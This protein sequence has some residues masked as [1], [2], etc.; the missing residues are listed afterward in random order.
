MSRKTRWALVPALS[1]LL[2]VAGCSDDDTSN[3]GVDQ[4]VTVD[5]GT[6]QDQG[7]GQ[8]KG[9]PPDAGPAVDGHGTTDG[10]PDGTS[11]QDDLGIGSNSGAICTQ[12]TPCP[13]P[14]ETCIYFEAALGKGMCLASCQQQGDT[15][16]VADKSTQISVCSVTGYQPGTWL[17]G[18]FCEL[19]GKT[20]KCPNDTD[21]K[22]VASSNGVA[23]FCYPK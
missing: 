16:P 2:L 10:I 23:Q 7:T 17:C 13:D 22:C 14:T 15:C 3:G 20:Y 19:G 9:D 4:S 11:G 5:Q 1:S 18:W 21:Y 6:S 12:S 8:D